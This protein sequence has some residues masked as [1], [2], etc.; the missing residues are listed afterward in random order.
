MGGFQ[1]VTAGLGEAGEQTGQGINQAITE[2]LKVRAQTHLEDVDKAHI[3]L[4]QQAQQQAYTIA[5]QQHELTR[6]Q[7]I[8]NGWKDIGIT[9]SPDGKYTRTF[10][11]D[12]T[13][14]TRAIPM[15]GVPP[16]SMEGMLN[17][18]KTLGGIKDEN[19]QPMFTPMQL[20]QI[21]FKMP[22]LYKEGPAGMLEAFTD[23]AKQR[24][25]EGQKAT[26]VPGFGKIDI[27]TPEGQAHFG[28][29]M[30]DTIY[31]RSLMAAMWRSQ[32]PADQ[33]GWSSNERNEYNGIL[34]KNKMMESLYLKM[35][36]ASMNSIQGMNPEFAAQTQK[37]L[38]DSV[39]PLYDEIQSKEEEIN[40]RHNRGT[41]TSIPGGGDQP[42][43]G[44]P[45]A[46]GVQ[47]DTPL[48]QRGK[49]SGWVAKG[50]V[51]V[52]QRR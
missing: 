16:D 43:A 37:T 2:A 18:Y 9:S 8:A 42:P 24:F 10:Y 19:G 36:E 30:M 6:Q 15:Q 33:S 4:A 41:P 46:K 7:M 52:K 23:I 28:Q 13:K 22:N 1:A 38:I 51:W 49:P 17:H 40:A 47:D 14:E 26:L 32:H 21:A 3:T 34:N 35:A 45:S 50:G 25:G 48:L 39:K 11:N 12:Q 20:K 44:A 29:V 27:T 5:Q 31:Q